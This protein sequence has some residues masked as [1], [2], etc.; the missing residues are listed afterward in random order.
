[1]SL[2]NHII[3]NTPVS[4]CDRARCTVDLYNKVTSLVQ[5]IFGSQGSYTVENALQSGH[6][7]STAS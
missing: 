5:P 2:E 1:M 4:P 6:L 7:S 3:H